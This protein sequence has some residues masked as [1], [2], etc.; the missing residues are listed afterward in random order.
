MN[1]KEFAKIHEFKFSN[2][3]EIS[4]SDKDEYDFVLIFRF[5]MVQLIPFREFT[6]F[7]DDVTEVRFFNAKKELR[8]FDYNGNLRGILIEDNGDEIT[9]EYYRRLY[10]GFGYKKIKIKEYI[11]FDNDGQAYVRSVRLCGAE[12]G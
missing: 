2:I 5:S 9:R 12:E 3:K 10:K 8:I 7:D 11:G 4:F 1:E 6:G